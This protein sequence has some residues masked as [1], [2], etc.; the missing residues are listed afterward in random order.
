MS[1][2]DDLEAAL[3]SH[4]IGEDDLDAV[5]SRIELEDLRAPDSARVP[6]LAL[7]LHHMPAPR[8]DAYAAQLAELRGVAHRGLDEAGL[9]AL[10]DG[11]DHAEDERPIVVPVLYEG[12]RS[13]Y[14]VALP[15]VEALGLTAWL[16]VPPA[17][18]DTPVAEQAA[19]AEAHELTPSP[20]EDPRVAMTWDE[21]RDVVA[22]GHVV[23]CH[24]ASHVGHGSIRDEADA[25]RELVAS[26]AR[27]EAE[28]GRPVRTICFVWGPEWGL[29]P[30]VDAHVAAA[31]YEL[32]ISN[33]RIQRL[34]D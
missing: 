33:T 6:V 23:C 17:F 25:R 10:L 8:T 22:R 24:T 15:L 18:L 20:D 16:V 21:L 30:A 27:L 34:P 12:Y 3:R 19:F 26:R 28:L 31:G 7:N 2:A 29:D 14:E 5:P 13:S 9:Q 4:L 1:L 32:L 11:R